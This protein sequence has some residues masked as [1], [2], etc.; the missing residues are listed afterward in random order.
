MPITTH[1][2]RR[3]RKTLRTIAGALCTTAVLALAACGTTSVPPGPQATDPAC[4]DIVLGAPETVLGQERTDTGSQG[5]LAWG[6]GEDAVVMRCGVTP[7]GP[8]TE[9]CQTIKDENDV[10]VDWIV[11]EEEGIVTFTTYGR[12][13]AI[14]VTVPRSLAPD[15]PS[16]GPLDLGPVVSTVPADERCIAPEDVE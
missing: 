1:P 15:Q 7:P 10:E 9:M 14:D 6:R 12:T 13:P 11:R 2:P 16:A 5:T 4:A 3:V 8:T